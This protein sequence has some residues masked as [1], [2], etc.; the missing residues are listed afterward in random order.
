MRWDFIS[1]ENSAGFHSPQE[2]ARVLADSIDLARQ[3][4]IAPITVMNGQNAS[5][6]LASQ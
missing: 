3:A 2:A 4:Q 5:L 1:S 6:E